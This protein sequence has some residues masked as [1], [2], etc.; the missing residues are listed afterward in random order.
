[1]RVCDNCGGAKILAKQLCSSCYH[2][3]Y[4]ARHREAHLAYRR[5]YRADNPELYHAALARRRT[6]GG[7]ELTQAER[8]AS[9]AR[10]QTIKG[11]P[12]VYCG[13][14]S[15]PMHV[16]HDIPIARGGDDRAGNLVQACAPCNLQKHTM[17][18]LEFAAKLFTRQRDMIH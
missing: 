6:P 1:V 7:V 16:D 10:R 15:G 2:K 8:A 12:C 11:T 17:T 5:Q 13:S 4:R 14:D 18:G 3:A 9:V